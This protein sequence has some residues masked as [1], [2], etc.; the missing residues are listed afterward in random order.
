[1]SVLEMWLEII[2]DDYPGRNVLM[3]L[4]KWEDLPEEM[5][6][7]EVRKYY[8]ILAKHKI[9][10]FFK[11]A[12]DVVVASIML[13]ILAIPILVISI[14]ITIDSPGG[15]VYRQTRITTYGKEF[16]I[17]KFRTMV[18]NADKI[19]GLV[20][21]GQDSRITRI[22]SFL[23]KYRLDELPQLLDVLN[24]DSGIIGTTKK[25]LDFTRVSL[26]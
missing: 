26:A 24:G 22:G 1:M 8:E 23:R 18:A 11:R 21:V 3:I 20:T 9:G 19:G 12:F 13:V 4:R 5:Q 17:H 2:F 7:P 14:L 16:Q 10:L 15:V 25:N 6:I